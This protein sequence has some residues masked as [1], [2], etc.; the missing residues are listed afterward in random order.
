MITLQKKFINA[1]CIAPTFLIGLTAFLASSALYAAA[2]VCLDAQAR[3]HDIFEQPVLSLTEAEHAVSGMQLSFQS[4]RAFLLSAL[5]HSAIPKA[6]KDA[7]RAK[8]ERVQ[9]Y[10]SPVASQTQNSFVQVQLEAWSQLRCGGAAESG[11]IDANYVEIET[12][13][14]LGLTIKNPELAESLRELYVVVCPGALTLASRAQTR[15]DSLF[16]LFAHELAHV[17]D[18]LGFYV[19]MS[20]RVGRRQTFLAEQKSLVSCFRK[21]LSSR[22]LSPKDQ[23]EKFATD[24]SDAR[25]SAVK[26]NQILLNKANYE[27]ILVQQSFFAGVELDAIAVRSPELIPDHWAAEALALKT[28]KMTPALRLQM[29][30]D[31]LMLFCEGALGDAAEI[32]D[33]LHLPQGF[34]IDW[35]LSHPAFSGIHGANTQKKLT[36]CK[37]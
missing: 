17:M 9:L 21:E 22:F 18:G 34:R 33:G 1:L 35:I 10:F 11:R 5:D 15:A 14:S 3:L 29:L 4:A 2:P 13:Q 19:N 30:Q 7:I 25:G 26:V 32:D 20:R 36:W 28:E 37:I 8:L 23:I 24:A 27:A 12:D 16:F 6:G 31:N